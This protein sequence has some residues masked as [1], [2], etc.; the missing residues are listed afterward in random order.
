MQRESSD[1]SFP[2][3]VV[4][5]FHQRFG[6]RPEVV[7]RAP[8]RVILLGA[9][10][11]YSEGWVIT[12]AIDRAV[13]LAAAP[14]TGSETRIHALDLDANA[15]LDL[16]RLPPPLVD[17]D[18]SRA[19]WVDYPAGVAWALAAAG[20]RPRAMDV[21]YG[22]DVPIGAGV[23]SSAAVEMAFL[24]AWE[25]FAQHEGSAGFGLDGAARARIGMSCENDYLGVMSGI[26]DQFTSLHGAA[27]KLIFL[28][29]RSLE[30]ELLPLPESASVLVADS[31]VR[32]RLTDF[33]YNDRRGEC[34][35]AV[36]L[37][38]S[39][40]D[41]IETLRDVSLEDFEL[42]SH[43]LPMT[44]RRRARHAIEEC[45]RVHEGA[46]ALERGDLAAFGRL[47]RQ[48]HLSSR[49]LYEVSIPEIDVL[50]AAAWAAPG[51]HGA[52]LVG[53][54]FG[55]CVMALVETEAAED[56]RARMIDTFARE[57]GKEPEVVACSIAD[58]AGIEPIQD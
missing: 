28:D 31:G 8:G 53:G 54:G 30:H 45:L 10:V 43:I 15:A 20:H 9:H 57:F 36:V 12:G 6:R 29:C 22:G 49:D 50:A 4:D 16:N 32:R 17:R 47:I 58:G 44:L 23:S 24:L 1:R 26:M 13:W 5:A 2:D 25:I 14:A 56:V 34:R 11:D 7:V 40:L 18:D 19:S 38:L 55:G 21:V 39:R 51:C 35:E 27:G 52:R 33:G 37:L 41:G 3:A 46:A 42:H 48:S